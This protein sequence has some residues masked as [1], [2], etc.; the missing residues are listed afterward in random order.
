M[1]TLSQI[2]S[3]VW[4]YSI[5]GGGAVAEGLAAIR[6][7]IDIIIRTTKGTDPLRPEFG[8]DVYKYHDAPANIAIPNIKR[9]ILNAIATWETRVVITYIRH[10]LDVSHL[11]FEI[12]Y[13]LV[14]DTLNDAITISLGN[15]GIVTGVTKNRLILQ[16]YIPPNPSNFQYQIQCILNSTAILPSPP[17]DGFVDVYEMYTWVKE[18]WANYGQWYLTADS[19]VGYINPDYTTGSLSISLLTKSRFVAGIPGLPIGYKYAVNI[20]V[21]GTLYSSSVDLFTP[22]QVRQWAQENIGFLGFWQVVTNPGSFNDD[23][24]ED[25]E[26]Y[27]QLLV[28]YTS[29]AESVLID[30]STI[31][32]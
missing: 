9:A 2:K 11:T 1:A 14:D 21:D 8:S 24:S 19:I 12:G 28:I 31:P 16:G 23:F 3:P 4:S 32:Q 22:D 7:C 26:L 17:V 5:Y 27:L 18:N 13:R 15:G 6:Q 29:Q 25:F 30:I 10:I 20:T